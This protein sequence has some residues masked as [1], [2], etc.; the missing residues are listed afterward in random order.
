M[1]PK[2]QYPW[3]P[4]APVPAP[5]EKLFKADW[6]DF[7]KKATTVEKDKLSGPI[8]TGKLVHH[9]RSTFRVKKAAI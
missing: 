3:N 9:G 5:L 8:L 2:T 7:R 6:S 4:F 1:N